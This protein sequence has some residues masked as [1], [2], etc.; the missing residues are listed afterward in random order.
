M[1]RLMNPINAT[2]WR[3]WA[4]N[5][6]ERY[7]EQNN[8]IRKLEHRIKSIEDRSYSKQLEQVFAKLR[9]LE[10]EMSS[11][12]VGYMEGFK[13][14]RNAKSIIEGLLEEGSNDEHS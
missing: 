13:A 6:A 4:V 11:G 5:V 7:I 12:H 1:N 14:G 2:T 10:R 8:R 3:H 9:Y